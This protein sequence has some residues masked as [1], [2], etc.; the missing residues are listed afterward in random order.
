MG[1]AGVRNSDNV[2]FFDAKKPVAVV[3]YS[4]DF[5]YNPKGS[6][7]WRNRFKLALF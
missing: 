2:K 3:Y 5:V 1:L 6:N 4:V 7:Y